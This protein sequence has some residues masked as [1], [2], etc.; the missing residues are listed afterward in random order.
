MHKLCSITLL[1]LL[2]YYLHVCLV[3]VIMFLFA[4]PWELGCEYAFVLLLWNTL[5]IVRWNATWICSWLIHFLHIRVNLSVWLSESEGC[6]QRAVTCA[7]A[8]E[9]QSSTAAGLHVPPS[10]VGHQ[11]RL[12]QP[13]DGSAVNRALLCVWSQT[14]HDSLR[15]PGY[16]HLCNWMANILHRKKT[17]CAALLI[18]G[19]LS[20]RVCL[21]ACETSLVCQSRTVLL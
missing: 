17:K 9:Q 3:T 20:G 10:G 4:W 7:D 6:F 1:L 12:L 18:G 16:I 2:L 5:L 15:Q 13:L 19:R 14:E 8:V 21:F 11:H